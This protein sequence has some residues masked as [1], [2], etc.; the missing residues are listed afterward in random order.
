[1]RQHQAG[2]L[3]AACTI[4]SDTRAGAHDR[5]GS[6]W[7]SLL[8]RLRGCCCAGRACTGDR[9]GLRRRACASVLRR[10]GLPRA[11]VSRRRFRV[12]F[13]P[14]PSSRRSTFR[15]A[16][17]EVWHLRPEGPRREPGTRQDQYGDREL[18][19][20]AERA[21]RTDPGEARDRR[22]I[23]DQNRQ[24]HRQRQEQRQQVPSQA[25]TAQHTYPGSPPAIS[26]SCRGAARSCF[27]AFGRCRHGG[28]V[29]GFALEW[30][31]DFAVRAGLL[32][33]ACAARVQPNRFH[34]ACRDTASVCPIAAQLTSRSRRILTT[35]CIAASIRSNAPL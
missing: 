23:E 28:M 21:G 14:R 1:M 35:S 9:S 24:D 18:D 19:E 22:R 2:V 3:S 10:A 17:S 27:S 30:K 4:T 32:P 8:R 15:R 31:P 11:R 12:G 25:K 20:R 13:R 26:G 33:E 34:A 5:H 7:R 29:P 16:A 6:G